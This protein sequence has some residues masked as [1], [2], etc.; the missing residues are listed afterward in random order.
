MSHAHVLGNGRC[1]A[2]Q[3]EGQRAQAVRR[4]RAH[5]RGRVQRLGSSVAEHV[6]DRIA[7]RAHRRHEALRRGGGDGKRREGEVT[8]VRR[9]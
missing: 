6:K 4:G 1:A 7:R 8:N 5:V 3:G 9:T 2:G